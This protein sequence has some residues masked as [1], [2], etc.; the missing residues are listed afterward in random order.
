MA[1]MI[2]AAIIAEAHH[3]DSK[4]CNLMVAIG[5][6]FLLLRLQFGI[7]FCKFCDVFSRKVAK[8]FTMKKRFLKIKLHSKS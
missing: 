3:L 6:R 7:I 8:F 2:T 1:P 5:F 4:I